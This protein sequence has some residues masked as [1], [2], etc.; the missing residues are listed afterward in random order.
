MELRILLE[1]EPGLLAWDRE[2][3]RRFWSANQDA[4]VAALIEEYT[5]LQGRIRW[6]L[7]EEIGI[8]A[9]LWANAP[10][11]DFDLLAEAAWPERLRLPDAEE[12]ERARRSL[13][14]LREAKL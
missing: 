7:G 9:L 13:A 4:H 11:R 1:R 2:S 6:I 10:R 12:V 3:I 5:Y 14:R 8:G